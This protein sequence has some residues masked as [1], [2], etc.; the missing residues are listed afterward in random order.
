MVTS[1]RGPG[2]FVCV[3]VRRVL[4]TR[5]AHTPT[6]PPIKCMQKLIGHV[7]STFHHQM[8]IGVM[9]GAR[10]GPAICQLCCERIW[11]NENKEKRIH[12]SNWSG[13]VEGIELATYWIVKS[14]LYHRAHIIWCRSSVIVDPLLEFLNSGK[15]LKLSHRNLFDFRCQFVPVLLNKIYFLFKF[16]SLRHTIAIDSVLL[17]VVFFLSIYV[18]MWCNWIKTGS[19]NHVYFC[20]VAFMGSTAEKEMFLSRC[21]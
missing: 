8:S 14:M 15:T 4:C 2:V 6:L 13:T 7:F 12:T 20:G 3:R 19:V 16:V 9:L 11:W 1:K 5:Q 10:T 17:L 18:F 21:H